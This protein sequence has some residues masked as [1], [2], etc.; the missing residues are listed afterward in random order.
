RPGTATSIKN[1]FLA[2][3]WTDTGVPA[4]IDGSVMSGFRAASK[5]TA[6][7][8]TAISEDAE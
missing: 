2:G 5:A 1:L 8:R 4:T 3:D 7:V 6:A